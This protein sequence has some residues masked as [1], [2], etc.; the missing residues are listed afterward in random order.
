[1]VRRNKN[2]INRDGSY[3]TVGYYVKFIASSLSKMRVIT[4]GKLQS[5]MFTTVGI[6]GSLVELKA[7]VLRVF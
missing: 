6:V 5:I 4:L 7:K 1:M 2:S 3:G